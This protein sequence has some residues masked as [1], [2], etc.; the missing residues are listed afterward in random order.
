MIRP[1]HHQMKRGTLLQAVLHEDQPVVAFGVF[2]DFFGFYPVA[3]S[4][5]RNGFFMSARASF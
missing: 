4:V 3:V 5:F 1:N 2:I